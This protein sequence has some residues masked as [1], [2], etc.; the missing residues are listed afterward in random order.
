MSPFAGAIHP[1]DA[2]RASSCK[3][4]RKYCPTGLLIGNINYN[5][6]N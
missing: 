1:P 3:A 5:Q 6:M 2:F 4:R